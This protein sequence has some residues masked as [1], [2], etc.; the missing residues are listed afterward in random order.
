MVSITFLARKDGALCAGYSEYGQYKTITLPTDESLLE[1]FLKRLGR[2]LRLVDHEF[3]DGSL[4]QFTLTQTRQ[5][6]HRVLSRLL[7]SCEGCGEPVRY[8]HTDEAGV[9]HSYCRGCYVERVLGGALDVH[10]LRYHAGYNVGNNAVL[11]SDFRYH[12]SGVLEDYL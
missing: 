12:G 5:R 10:E 1:I 9:T 3:D 11:N 6:L 8:H 7:F 2:S 4:T